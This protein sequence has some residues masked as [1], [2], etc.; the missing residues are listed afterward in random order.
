MR[1]LAL[2]LLVLIALATPASADNYPP[3]EPPC[4]NCYHTADTG[5]TDRGTN[6]AKV[7]VLL[8]VVGIGA[9]VVA[10]RRVTR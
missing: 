2:A 3:T 1:K 7:A 8:G 9:V 4:V 5:F 6:A 10:R